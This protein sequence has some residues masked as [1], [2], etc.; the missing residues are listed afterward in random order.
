VPERGGTERASDAGVSA[1]L[2]SDRAPPASTSIRPANEPIPP[3]MALPER[4]LPSYVEKISV[5]A[6]VMLPGGERIDG[7]FALSP[8]APFR[9]G[10]ETLLELLNGTD[11]VLPLT[12]A[13]GTVVLLS[14]PAI[15]WVEVEDGIDPS[16][17]RPPTFWITREEEVELRLLDGRKIVGIV[18]MELPEHLNRISDYLNLPEDF[19]PVTTRDGTRFVNKS[20]V[21]GVTLFESSPRPGQIA[22]TIDPQ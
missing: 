8:A 19:F 4:V 11:R 15:D 3:G 10:P 18:A 14:R 12:L 17:V 6:S 21:V 2:L 9:D 16:W 7:N 5:P 13:D 22:G 20:R 1:F